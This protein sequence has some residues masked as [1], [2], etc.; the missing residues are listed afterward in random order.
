MKMPNLA[1]PDLN[2]IVP[3]ALLMRWVI[4]FMFINGVPILVIIE[5]VMGW[6]EIEVMLD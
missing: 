6:V 4:D 1:L 2:P 5:Y 3:L